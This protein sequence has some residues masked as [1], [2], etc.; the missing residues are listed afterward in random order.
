[1]VI[2]SAITIVILT[3][4]LG[5]ASAESSEF[6]DMRRLA[7]MTPAQFQARTTLHDDDLDTVATITTADGFVERRPLLAQM[8]DDVFL[9]AFIDKTTG[10]TAYQV[11]V[12]VRY[13]GYAWADWRMA[14]YST[15][16]SPRSIGTRRIARLRAS[17]SRRLPCSRSETIGFV[18]GTGLIKDNAA[19]YSA[20]AA[21]SWRFKILAQDGRE[22]DLR[23][24]M[25]EIAG[26]LM[27]VDTYR[28]D[29]H[30]PNF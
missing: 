12:T 20:E 6:S 16:T 13:R 23:L 28:A 5:Q 18:V 25:A 26:L 30:L 7:R 4:A 2:R 21:T 17:C 1:M 22:R 19:L 9:R 14:N 27:A 15:P 29:R 11:Y 3:L 24:S 8:P 10:H